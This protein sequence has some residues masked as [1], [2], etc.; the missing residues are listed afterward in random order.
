MKTDFDAEH[1]SDDVSGDVKT[2][3]VTHSS[4]MW[5][6]RKLDALSFIPWAERVH[7]CRSFKKLFVKD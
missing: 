2:M 4:G 1:K 5:T 6:R 3:K 7:P